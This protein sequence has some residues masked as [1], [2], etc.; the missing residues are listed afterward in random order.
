MATGGIFT[1]I[2]NDGKQDRMLMATAL[3]HERLRSI[4]AFKTRN[5]G[6]R[7]DSLANLPTLMDIEKTHILFTNAHF[8][9]F[10]AIG[11]EYNKVRATSGN[12]ALG[13]GIQFSIPQ[14]GDFFHDIACH[15]VLTQPT[16]TITATDDSDEP[17]MRW[18]HFPGERLLKRVQQEVN[19][20][21]LDEYTY[22]ATNMHRE[23]R[24][25]TDK[26]LSW[27]RCVG[28]EEPEKGWVR[29][30]DW[31]LN[32]VASANVTHRVRASVTRGNQT[33]TGQKTG[34]LEMFIP[35]LF[36]YNKDVRL[37]VPSVAIPYGQRFINI[38]LAAQDELVDV[39][40]RGASSF[41]SPGG[42]V[43]TPTV[44]T[45]ELYINNIF[46]NP[47][48][49][50]IYIKR[51]GFSLIRVHRQ[52]LYTANTS[53]AEVLLQSMKWPIEFL[54]V[55]MKVKDYHAS[56]VAATKREHLDKW[57]TFHSRS[58]GSYLTTGQNVYQESL[59]ATGTDLGI[60]QA[61]FTANSEDR[62]NLTGTSTL[63]QTVAA[64]D[65]IKVAGLYLTVAVGAAAT[66]ATTGV[67]V[68]QAPVEAITASA[69]ILAAARFV[70]VQGLEYETEVCTPTLDTV[71]IRAHGIDIYNNFPDGFFNAYTAYHFGGS[72]IRSPDD[73]GLC[74]VPFCLYPGA[75]QPSGH[76]N[77][78]RAREFYLNYTSSVIDAN[79]EGTLVVI[80]SAI[81]F[82]LIS[83]GSAVL[84]YST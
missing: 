83:D 52:Q 45:I 32:A 28:Q 29:Q 15:V 82:L 69:A 20:N 12:P 44:S 17:T 9:P 72:N 30:P 22:H 2:T 66:A 42:S 16:L 74:F 36:W 65:L 1:I 48:V 41:A 53:S 13:Q 61:V 5:N 63:A 81:N 54:F 57:H 38:D 40:P 23:Y 4:N 34:N 26:Q 8:K 60:A 37:A 68:H 33:P 49:H 59:L 47:E 19:G 79:T 27:Y 31:S 11:Y 50:K 55:G 67:E 18:A 25:C 21:P 43:N 58:T 10:A 84:R 14:F 62:A 64:G 71:T 51:I 75:Y 56:T 3:L 73:C 46:V 78:S 70:T 6:G 80:A 7:P 76:I 24:V 39:V 77:V 35:L